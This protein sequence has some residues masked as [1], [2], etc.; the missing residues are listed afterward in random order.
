[1]VVWQPHVFVLF[2][3]SCNGGLRQGRG[4]YEQF[5]ATVGVRK[6]KLEDSA[7]KQTKNVSKSPLEHLKI[8]LGSRNQMHFTGNGVR[9]VLTSTEHDF[10]CN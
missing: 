1:M 4:N 8:I 2:F 6:K 10:E 3:F 9:D 5:Q 7:R